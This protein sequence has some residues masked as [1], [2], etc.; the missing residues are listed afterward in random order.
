MRRFTFALMGVIAC[1]LSVSCEDKL[2]SD[3]KKNS[4]QSGDGD[5]Y[6]SLLDSAFYYDE[7]RLCQETRNIYDQNGL[8]QKSITIDYDSLGS[9][10]ATVEE[11]YTYSDKEGKNYVLV[12][13]KNGVDVERQEKSYSGTDGD[14]VSDTRTYVKHGECWFLTKRIYLKSENHKCRGY[15]VQYAIY[16]GQSFVVSRIDLINQSDPVTKTSL[17]MERINYSISYKKDPSD[18]DGLTISNLGSENWVKTIRRCKSNGDVLFNQNL[19]SEDSI[20]W[21]DMGAYEYEYD[22]NGNLIYS[23]SSKDGRIEG[24]EYVTYSDD[25]RFLSSYEYSWNKNGTDSVLQYSTVYYYSESGRLDSAVILSESRWVWSLPLNLRD[26]TKGYNYGQG[27]N[28]LTGS[29]CVVLFDS[30]G[31]PVTETLYR[32]DDNGNMEDEAYVRSTLTYDSFGNCTGFA[33]SQ[34]DE[35]E[36]TEIETQS[37]AY[38]SEGRQ[39]SSHSRFNGQTKSVSKKEPERYVITTTDYEST[40]RTDYDSFGNV[41]YNLDVYRRHVLYTFSDGRDPEE[42]NVDDREEKYYSTR[43]IK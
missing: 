23:E 28:G 30:K 36:W 34:N 29:K 37:N 38:D 43:K 12:T 35:G 33:V 14:Y 41:S 20:T 15:N 39:L 18:P 27:Q 32:M 26:I 4:G 25:N 31:N 5:S 21:R 9:P 11:A 13:S 22:R 19:I 10:S 3:E 42:E 6:K 7:G 2:Q 24:K 17:D 40:K 1:V 8:V 16:N